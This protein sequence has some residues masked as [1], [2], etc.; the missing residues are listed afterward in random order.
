M[1]FTALSIGIAAMCNPLR[2]VRQ[3]WPYVSVFLSFAAFVKWNGSVVLGI[4]LLAINAVRGLLTRIGD[5]SNHV[6]TIHL[7][8]ML[9]IW[10]FFAFFSLP[11]LVP[12]AFSFF[13]MLSSFTRSSAKAV[14][15]P[16]TTSI[17]LKACA[18][19]FNSKIL[20][21]IYLVATTILSAAVVRFNTIIHPFTLAD[22][23]HY[24]FYIFR[25]T[26]RRGSLV[27]LGLVL[28]YTICRWVVWDA[29][30]GFNSW[31]DGVEQPA[32]FTSYPFWSPLSQ[33]NKRE[34]ALPFPCEPN[35]VKSAS[36][37]QALKANLQKDPLFL[38]RDSVS[39]S[40]GLVFLLATALSLITAPLVEPR[41]FIIPYVMWR[42]MVP[43]WHM[44]DHVSSP[45]GN[46]IPF[47]RHVAAYT[48][49]YDV[50]LFLET[51][52]YMA[53]NVATGYMFLYK[54]YVW[55]AED[56]TVLE[57]GNMQRFMW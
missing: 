6:A 36:G 9:Y 3:I 16:Q 57:A 5:K 50:R 14:T 22:N 7:A 46:R 15:T 35:A 44:E 24:M 37:E 54:P 13:N 4:F 31:A 33:K 10:P 8:Q 28:P 2:V 51:A 41:Y 39:T 55:K 25:Y 56:G 40:T 47:I 34:C 12:C 32:P 19:F 53:I 38:S 20:W 21:P 42:L 45:L 26:I 29:L 17:P 23:R 18:A 30:G 52:W 11:L 43:A 27:R 1:I 49:S 48:R